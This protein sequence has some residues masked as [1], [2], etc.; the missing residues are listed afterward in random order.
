MRPE[1]VN[2]QY[3][4]APGHVNIKY[5][6]DMEFTDTLELFATGNTPPFDGGVEGIP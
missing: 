1:R 2:K 5:I 3:G 4:I 6:S